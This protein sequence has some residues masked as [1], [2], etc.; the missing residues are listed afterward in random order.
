MKYIIYTSN[1][2][3]VFTRDQVDNNN[4]LSWEDYENSPLYGNSYLSVTVDFEKMFVFCET[5]S[6]DS[7]EYKIFELI[8]K[9]VETTNEQLNRN[10]QSEMK[11]ACKNNTCKCFHF[12]TL[13][14]DQINSCFS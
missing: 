11:E 13:S 5:S 3:F 10:N 2:D 4:F 8:N 6:G 9:P 7:A 12:C 1:G 14:G